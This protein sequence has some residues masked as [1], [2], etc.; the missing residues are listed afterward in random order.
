LRSKPQHDVARE[1]RRLEVFE[2]EGGLCRE[3]AIR[4]GEAM[5]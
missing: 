1:R 4:E 2:R 5:F 3:G